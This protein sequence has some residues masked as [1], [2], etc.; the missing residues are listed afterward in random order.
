MSF[1]QYDS[2]CSLLEI[3][4]ETYLQARNALIDKDLIA[5]DGQ[6][7]NRDSGPGGCQNGCQTASLGFP[8]K[9]KGPAT[10]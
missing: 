10:L 6:W 5:F 8:R 9:R 1:Y 7:R 4:L 2:I 3:P